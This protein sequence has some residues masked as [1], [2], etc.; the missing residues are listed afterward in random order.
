MNLDIFKSVFIIAILFG[1]KGLRL[2][3]ITKNFYKLIVKKNNFTKTLS[4]FLSRIKN[5]LKIDK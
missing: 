4:S 2:R 3:P 1:G 5:I